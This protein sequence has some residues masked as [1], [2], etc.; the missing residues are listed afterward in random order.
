MEV[1]KVTC[2]TC[3]RVRYW[4]EAKDFDPDE[5]PECTSKDITFKVVEVTE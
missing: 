4:D 1:Y 2:G 3:G 5:C